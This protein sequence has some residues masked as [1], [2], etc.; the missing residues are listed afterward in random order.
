MGFGKADFSCVSLLEMIQIMKVKQPV[1][2]Q[3]DM[4][5]NNNEKPVRKQG[6]VIQDI[7]RE[8]LLYSA[9]GKTIHVLNPTA[10]VI[11]DLCDGAHTIEDMEHEIRSSFSFSREHNV[12]ED[13]KRTLGIFKDKGILDKG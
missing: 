1:K 3:Q 10:K 7:G 12:I 5:M 9:E 6:I 4:D 8:T 2:C 13:V 11:W